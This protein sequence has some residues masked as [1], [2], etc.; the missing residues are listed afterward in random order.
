MKDDHSV[1]YL[2][3]DYR[4]AHCGTS[5]NLTLQHRRNRGMGGTKRP[6]TYAGFIALCWQSNTQLESDPEFARLGIE[7]GWKI[8]QSDPREDRDVPVWFEHDGWRWLTDDGNYR[9]RPHH[10][11]EEEDSE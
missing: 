11:Y 8:E 1:V 5:Q 2:R 10:E 7:K 3:D 6:Y 4:C 9:F